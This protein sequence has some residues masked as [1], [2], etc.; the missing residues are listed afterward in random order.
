MVTSLCN[1]TK[2]ITTVTTDKTF[3]SPAHFIMINKDQDR[4]ELLKTFRVSP[5]DEPNPMG[6]HINTLL[7]SD[8]VRSKNY[9]PDHT[10]NIS[11]VIPEDKF[12][13]HAQV[14]MTSRDQEGGLGLDISMISTDHDF[15]IISRHRNVLITDEG[16]NN[17]S[18]PDLDTA[19]EPN[20]DITQ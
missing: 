8:N 15:N 20:L 2:L 6:Y 14:I 19:S 7:S 16:S 18:K 17:V 10:K 12:I 9:N 13:F 11:L 5:S 3:I 4:K 1:G